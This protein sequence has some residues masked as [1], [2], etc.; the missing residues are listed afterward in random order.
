MNRLG[1]HLNRVTQLGR[2]TVAELAARRGDGLEVKLLWSRRSGAL[3][4]DVLHVATHERFTI[5]AD[6]ANALDVY[7]HPFAYCLD[8]GPELAAAA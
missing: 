1:E 2:P 5:D 7:Y 8:G 3:W 6:P 4:V